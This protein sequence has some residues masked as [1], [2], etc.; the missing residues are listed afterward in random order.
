MEFNFEHCHWNSNQ[1]ILNFPCK[2]M[3][4]GTEIMIQIN[5]Y[6]H[7]LTPDEEQHSKMKNVPRKLFVCTSS[8]YFQNFIYW[9][10]KWDIIYVNYTLYFIMVRPE[11]TVSGTNDC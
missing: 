11:C 9:V 2:T 8:F 7:F 5:L 1:K 3:K 4:I 10:L 6:M